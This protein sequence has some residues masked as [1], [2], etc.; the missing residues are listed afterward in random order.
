MEDSV[1]VSVKVYRDDEL[2]STRSFDAFLTCNNNLCD[3]DATD[4]EP[5]LESTVPVC[6]GTVTGTV[7][8]N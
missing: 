1:S 3:P 6:A 2:E 5:Y 8:D 4:K 7:L